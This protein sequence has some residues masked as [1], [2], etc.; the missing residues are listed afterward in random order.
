MIFC[1]GDGLDVESRVCGIA[2]DGGGVDGA[3]ATLSLGS[4]TSSGAAPAE[5]W[6]ACDCTGISC[7]VGEDSGGTEASVGAPTAA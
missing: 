2:G 6:G 1:S 5:L 4:W 7:N 3:G